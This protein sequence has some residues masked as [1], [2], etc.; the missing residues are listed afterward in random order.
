MWIY[1]SKEVQYAKNLGYKV[2]DSDLKSVLVLFSK[3][4]SSLQVDKNLINLRRKVPKL[5][6]IYNSSSYE[7]T[8]LYGRLMD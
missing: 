7:R 6:L 1:Y 4:I 3:C 8:I 5:C 2:G